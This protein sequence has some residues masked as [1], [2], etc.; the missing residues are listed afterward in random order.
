MSQ[1]RVQDLMGLSVDQRDAIYSESPDYIRVDD[2]QWQ[3]ATKKV[4][5]DQVKTEDQLQKVFRNYP[6]DSFHVSGI[7]GPWYEIYNALE[8]I[9]NHPEFYGKAIPKELRARGLDFI[10]RILFSQ[11]IEELDLSENSIGH[12]PCFIF[13]M[14]HLKILSLNNNKISSIC[15]PHPSSELKRIYL[16]ENL[17]RSSAIENLSVLTSLYLLD[18]SH[19][20]IEEIPNSFSEMKNLASLNLAYNL[21]T[22]IDTSILEEMESLTELNLSNN[23]ISEINGDFN[24]M[25]YLRDLDLSN[26]KITE[27]ETDIFENAQSLEFLNVFGN[28]GLKFVGDEDNLEGIEII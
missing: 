13:L 26:N 15:I 25:N 7:I 11:K 24:N 28:R 18:L 9:K 17:L 27:I 23:L 22:Q 8:D 16:S 1:K 20:E 14:D 5:G 12:I 10:P 6:F 2:F 21:L 4:F 3:L 19:N